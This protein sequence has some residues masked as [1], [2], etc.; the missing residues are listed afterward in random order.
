MT[1]DTPV[2]RWAAL[3]E[4]VAASPVR[5]S[6][7]PAGLPA[8]APEALIQAAKQA[9]GRVPALA[10]LLGIDMPPPPGP[11]RP[12]PP[13]GRRPAR[14]PQPPKPPKPPEEPQL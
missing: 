5:R 7:K 9:A 13:Q 2:D 12:V 4:A 3:L 11:L 8:D 10:Q 6:V 14:P 1:T